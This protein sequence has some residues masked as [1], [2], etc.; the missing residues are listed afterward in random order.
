[1]REQREF[2]DKGY[3]WSWRGEKEEN[4]SFIIDFI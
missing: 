3:A 4:L 1:M 2:E